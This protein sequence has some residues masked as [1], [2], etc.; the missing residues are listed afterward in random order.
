M[1]H[2]WEDLLSEDNRVLKYAYCQRIGSLHEY[3]GLDS[4]YLLSDPYLEVYD[5][6]SE[7]IV[8]MIIG[9]NNKQAVTLIQVQLLRMVLM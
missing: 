7:I 1:M 6:K 3:A 4:S 2:W 9:R 8:E 5:A